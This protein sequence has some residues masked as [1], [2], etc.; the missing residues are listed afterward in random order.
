MLRRDIDELTEFL[1]F[2]LW[3]SF[4]SVKAF[5]S[6]DYETAVFYP[7]DDRFL[8]ERDQFSTHYFVQT[9]SAPPDRDEVGDTGRE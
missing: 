9:H 2:T 3:Y 1:M 8:V 7:E 6:Q 5:A 4:D